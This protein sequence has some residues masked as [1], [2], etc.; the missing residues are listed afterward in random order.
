MQ[1]PSIAD[2]SFTFFLLSILHVRIVTGR[3]LRMCASRN[4]SK[5][6]NSFLLDFAHIQI[7]ELSVLA[8]YRLRRKANQRPVSNWALEAHPSGKVKEN[9]ASSPSQGHSHAAF[10]LI[11]KAAS[12]LKATKLSVYQT[13]ALMKTK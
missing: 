4:V 10:L 1:K 13:F 12:M 6:K 2:K 11:A 9:G 8:L 3:A 7:S 5:Q